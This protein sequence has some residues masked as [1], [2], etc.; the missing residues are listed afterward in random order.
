MPRY[1]IDEAIRPDLAEQQVRSDEEQML[2]NR[3]YALTE[4]LALRPVSPG[5]RETE[6]AA[7]HRAYQGAWRAS[8]EAVQAIAKRTTE[9]AKE[10]RQDD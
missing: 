7:N 4:F 1:E 2:T 10:P 8:M 3:L 9:W 5:P 6:E